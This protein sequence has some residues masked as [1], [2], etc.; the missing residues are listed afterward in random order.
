MKARATRAFLFQITDEGERDIIEKGEVR[1][2]SEKQFKE[3]QVHGLV[4]V[5]EEE[6]K[7]R[8]KKSAE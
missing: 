8:A 3:L 6:S 2:L 1:E 4:P 7:P 5:T